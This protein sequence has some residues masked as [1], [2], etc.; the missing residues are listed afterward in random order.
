MKSME[1]YYWYVKITQC[2]YMEHGLKDIAFQFQ[3]H[4]ASKAICHNFPLVCDKL[5]GVLALTHCGLVTSYGDKN[6]GR[7]WLT[8]DK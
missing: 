4:K 6:L 3:K 2:V 5:L 7:H 1:T 8:S